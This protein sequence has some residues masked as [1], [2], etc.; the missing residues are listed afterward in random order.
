MKKSLLIFILCFSCATVGY[1]LRLQDKT[2]LIDPRFAGYLVYPTY[3]IKCKYP[4][5]RFFKDCSKV[6]V[7]EKFDL[8]DKDTLNTLSGANFECR[9]TSRFKY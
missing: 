9:S 7:V 4:E 5:R 2:L 6:P 8:M 1:Q 3:E